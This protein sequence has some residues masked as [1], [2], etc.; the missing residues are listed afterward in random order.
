MRRPAPCDALDSGLSMVDG[1]T[2]GDALRAG[3]AAQPQFEE[4]FQELVRRLRVLLGK[5]RWIRTARRE[6]TPVD[7]LARELA[8]EFWIELQ[9]NPNKLRAGSVH[10]WGAV[11]RELHRFLD[12]PVEHESLESVRSRTYWHFR[13]KVRRVCQQNFTR[14]PGHRSFY[15]SLPESATAASATQAEI[16]AVVENAGLFI[17]AD[18]N[19]QKGGQTPPVADPDDIRAFVHAALRGVGKPIA[20]T[21]LVSTAWKRLRPAAPQDVY[22][23][24][25]AIETYLSAASVDSDYEIVQRA[26]YMAIL[27][28]IYLD[29]LSD[30]L[31]DELTRLLRDGIRSGRP[32]S[33]RRDLAISFEAFADERRLDDKEREMLRANIRFALNVSR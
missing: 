16:D 7:Q 13:R 26:E 1:V 24:S 18:Y 27:A 30:A 12:Q 9:A 10:G 2:F 25:N 11:E 29:S 28:S 3:D 4:A 31:R 14:A 8:S 20:E 15:W 23:D 22:G 5:R 19:P 33:A 17:P 32:S 21:A 6:T